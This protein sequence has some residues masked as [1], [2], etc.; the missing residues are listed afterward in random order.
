MAGNSAAEHG[1][2]TIAVETR[3]V[4]EYGITLDGVWLP[5]ALLRRLEAH[6]PWSAPFTEGTTDQERVLVH[7]ALAERHNREGLHRGT[8]LPGF[9]AAIPFEPTAPLTKIPHTGTP[10]DGRPAVNSATD[11]RGRA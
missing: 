9:L 1:S 6:G 10:G 4:V 5:L 2:G 3:M 7:H 11:T 8:G